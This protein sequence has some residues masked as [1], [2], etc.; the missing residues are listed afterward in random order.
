LHKK[1]ETG[2]AFQFLGNSLYILLFITILRELLDDTGVILN[3][4][5]SFVFIAI[6]VV[7]G[8]VQKTYRNGWVFVVFIVDAISF[9]DHLSEVFL[10]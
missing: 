7:L 6:L 9:R 8:D 3:N 5:G 2:V 1:R 4:G 10:P